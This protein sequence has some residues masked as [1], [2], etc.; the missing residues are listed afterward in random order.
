MVVEMARASRETDGNWKTIFNR[1][2][3]AACENFP[4]RLRPVSLG[5]FLSAG[6]LPF[7]FRRVRQFHDIV[8]Q[9]PVVLAANVENVDEIFLRTGD[10]F[11]AF[12]AGEFAFERAGFFEAVAINDFHRP[13]DS[14]DAA[15]EPHI[16]VSPAPYPPEQ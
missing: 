16:A 14:G 13:M 10:G 5:P 7:R 9:V 8:E 2:A 1:Q 4:E 6:F 12:D 11:E 15:G 3:F